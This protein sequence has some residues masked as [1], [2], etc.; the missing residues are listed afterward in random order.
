MQMHMLHRHCRQSGKKINLV[1]Y[2][3]LSWWDQRERRNDKPI[4]EGVT[5]VTTAVFQGIQ[6]Y[7]R[8][9]SA[10]KGIKAPGF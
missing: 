4:F 1:N 3:G 7:D 2:L 5:S 6:I 9:D 10:L 8:L